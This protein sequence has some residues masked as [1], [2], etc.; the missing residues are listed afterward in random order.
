MMFTISGIS[1]AIQVGKMA[2]IH[3]IHTY[4]GGG[5]S[6]CSS[7]YALDI[8]VGSL[9]EWRNSCGLTAESTVQ[10]ATLEI[11]TVHVLLFMPKFQLLTNIVL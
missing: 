7:L 4:I 6:G 2:L 3:G 11:Y 8:L 10:V 1:V 9:H 5:N